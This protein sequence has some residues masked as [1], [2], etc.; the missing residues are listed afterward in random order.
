M[1][2]LYPENDV[3]KEIGIHATVMVNKG[4]AHY[5]YQYFFIIMVEF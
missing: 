1:K 2:S 5:N 4:H 3:P